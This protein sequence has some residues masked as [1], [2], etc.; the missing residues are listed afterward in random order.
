MVAAT[1]PLKELCEESTCSV[2][3]DFFRDPVTI[4]GVRQSGQ[5]E[6]RVCQKH[7]EPL[8]LFCKADEALI[9]VVCDQSQNTKITKSFP[10]KRLPKSSRISSCDCYWRCYRRKEKKFWHVK[11]SILEEKAITCLSKP[12]ENG[13]RQ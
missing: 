8:K 6:R 12:K 4:A 3:L 11:P 5:L 7:Q 13:R 10:W 1:G 2:C 9:C